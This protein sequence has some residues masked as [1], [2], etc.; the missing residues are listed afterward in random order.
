MPGIF[1][2]M[3]LTKPADTG[4]FKKLELINTILEFGKY[5]KTR[6]ELNYIHLFFTLSLSA[7]LPSHTPSITLSVREKSF[8]FFKVPILNTQTNSNV[9]NYSES[10]TTENCLELIFSIPKP[11][12]HYINMTPLLM[13]YSK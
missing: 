13:I 4:D 1:S 2:I 6:K 5:F 9:K 8:K 12:K 10:I 3:Y 7:P 11:Y